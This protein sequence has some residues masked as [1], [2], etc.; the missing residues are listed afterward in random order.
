VYQRPLLAVVL[1]AGLGHGGDAEDNVPN[2]TERRLGKV[3]LL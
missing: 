2:V 3:G 1:D